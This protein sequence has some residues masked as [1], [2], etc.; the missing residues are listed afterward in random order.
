MKNHAHLNCGARRKDMNDH[1]SYIYNL[2]SC[3]IKQLVGD[4]RSAILSRVKLSLNYIEQNF[5][6]LNFDVYVSIQRCQL[7]FYYKYRVT[8]IS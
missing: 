3:K 2:I 5:K 4:C 1:C 8:D 7:H 6:V